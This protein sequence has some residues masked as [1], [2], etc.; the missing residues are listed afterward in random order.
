MEILTSGDVRRRE[1]ALAL[2]ETA[3]PP[4]NG[5]SLELQ[6][7][8]WEIIERVVVPEVTKTLVM[9]S[10]IQYGSGH[11]EVITEPLRVRPWPGGPQDVQTLTVLQFMLD[12]IVDH[13]GLRDYFTDDAN[14]ADFER[15]NR[16]FNREIDSID[17]H[18]RVVISPRYN[19]RGLGGGRVDAR[20]LHTLITLEPKPARAN[21]GPSSLRDL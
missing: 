18:Y 6:Q 20:L 1:M 7:R 5:L 4:L 19:E 12:R 17:L 14:R 9:M 3:Q 2:L 11:S 16:V 21:S 8:M 13:H 10:R 15:L